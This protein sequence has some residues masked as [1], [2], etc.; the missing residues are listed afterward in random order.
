MAPDVNWDVIGSVAKGDPKTTEEVYEEAADILQSVDDAAF[1]GDSEKL[2]LLF[3][4]ALKIIDVSIH[5]FSNI[6]VDSE[7]LNQLWNGKPG[8]VLV[9]LGGRGHSGPPCGIKEKLLC[10]ETL[11]FTLRQ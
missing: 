6:L 3:K 10:H 5:D 1:A 11:F 7:W 8:N 4:S 2:S 9:S